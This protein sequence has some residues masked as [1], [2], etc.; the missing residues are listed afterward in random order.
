MVWKSGIVWN[1][2]SRYIRFEIRAYDWEDWPEVVNYRMI[3]DQVEAQAIFRPQDGLIF[4]DHSRVKRRSS[5]CQTYNK[6]T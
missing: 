2:D 4:K 1:A 5:C 6:K 3:V